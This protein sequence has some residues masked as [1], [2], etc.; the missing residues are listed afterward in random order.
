[1]RKICI[2][3]LVLAFFGCKRKQTEQDTYSP[4][5]I[6]LD[7]PVEFT[8][9]QRSTAPLPKSDDTLLL[10]LDDITAGQVLVTLSWDDGE[11]VLPMRSLRQND[12]LPFT[13]GKHVYKLKLK[14]LTNLVFGDD[15]ALF[16]LWPATVEVEKLLLEQDEIE[17]LISSL[18]QLSDAKFIRN[19][20]EYSVDEAVAH[21]KMMWEWKRAE[22]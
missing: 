10:T 19:G 13:L 18:R 6:S 8:V 14:Q 7:S 1:M 12:I 9:T 17:K 2:L 22:I 20:K 4:P 5:P 3:L 11:S 16:Q 21:M 15:F